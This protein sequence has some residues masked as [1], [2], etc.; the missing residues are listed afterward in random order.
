MIDENEL[1]VVCHCLQTHGPLY[2]VNT[3]GDIT[4]KALGKSVEYIDPIACPDNKWSN[5][6]SNSK[7]YV[8]GINCPIYYLF[9]Q[10]NKYPEINAT[11][12]F[13]EILENILSES[14]RVLKVGGCVIFPTWRSKM[15]KDKIKQSKLLDFVYGHYDV[16]IIDAKT[17][18][19][20]LSTKISPKKKI[21]EKDSILLFTK[22]EP[23]I[24]SS[25][26][27][28]R[29]V[30]Q[31]GKN[32]QNEEEKEVYVDKN[33]QNGQNG[34]NE[35]EKEVYVDKNEQNGQNEEEKEV[36]VDKNEQKEDDEYV[37]KS[38]VK[39]IDGEN[40]I[41]QVLSY[42]KY[43]TIY[44][45]ETDKIESVSEDDIKTYKFL[46]GGRDKSVKKQNKTK[47]QKKQKKQ[48]NK[49]KT[50]KQMYI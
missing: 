5:I 39:I 48:K 24:E 1:V 17:F 12:E 40:R 4:N 36:Y 14:Y 37:G 15:N 18:K 49:R 45:P 11:P 29:H 42:T 19:F 41:G 13:L 33:E 23:S 30:E 38:I 31:N 8:Y 46:F 10:D 20:N 34:Q 26:E 43:Y 47:K 9:S 22:I 32:G 16:N 50:K 35:E 21:N 25:Y 7:R 6:K 27:K 3:N 28:E 44:Y 2:Y